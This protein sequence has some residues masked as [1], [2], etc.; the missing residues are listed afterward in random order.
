MEKQDVKKG[1]D[2]LIAA[3]E[4]D[5]KSEPNRE[6]EWRSKIEWILQRA[7]QYAEHCGTDRD[8]VLK[9]W[10]ENRDYWYMNYYQ[11]S[12]QPDLS[13]DK[14]KVYTLN[15]W[16]E[17]AK[18]R[19]GEDALDWKFKCPVCGNVQTMRMFKDAG[20]DPHSAYFNCASRYGLGGKSDCKWTMGG[21]FSVGGVFVIDDK[22][23]P[24][25]VFDFAD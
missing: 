3:M 9:A 20:I 1:Y 16:L 14:V 7:Q 5:I 22:F 25:H 6:K 24:R 17:E 13:S 12:K 11:E 2:S 18:Q 15:Q 10:E 8:T 23:T 19:F 4:S 21:L